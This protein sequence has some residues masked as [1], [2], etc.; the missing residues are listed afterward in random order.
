[1]GGNPGIFAELTKL[2]LT[3]Y[4]ALSAMFGH[5]MAAPV[6]GPD[7][8]VMGC[9]VWL[10]AA[11]A[12]VLNNIQDRRYDQ[13]F[14]RTR[15]RCLPRKKISVR[16]AAVLAAVLI[17]TGLGLLLGYPETRLPGILGLSALVCYNGLYTPLKKKRFA[18]VWPG[19]LCGMLPPAMGW[20]AVPALYRSG[21]LEELFFLM[22]VLGIWQ[23]PH[24]L[25]L[26]ARQPFLDPGADIF[27][28]LTRVWTRTELTLQ[29]LI[30]VSLY[31][32]SM[33]LFLIKGGIAFWGFS[34]ALGALA[35]SLPVLMVFF[36]SFLLNR[37]RAGGFGV[38]NLSMFVFMILGILDRV[39]V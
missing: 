27:P 30:W 5:V 1:M 11:G 18:A 14:A 34:A 21:T 29:I 36:S 10:L 3:V 15:N 13:W 35:L 25:V 32:L 7:T 19:V 33:L 4:I 17:L 16:S 39:F 24:F 38:V 20:T 12:A 6:P 23:I 2:H 26:W 8:L 37:N 9:S 22:L 28:C 31:S